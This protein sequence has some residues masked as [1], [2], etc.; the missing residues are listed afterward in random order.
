MTPRRCWIPACSR[1]SGPASSG[2]ASPQAPDR[3]EAG[4]GPV[5]VGDV[6]DY[7][8]HRH[9]HR[10]GRTSRICSAAHRHAQRTRVSPRLQA[11]RPLRSTSDPRPTRSLRACET[12]A[13]LVNASGHRPDAEAVSLCRSGTRRLN[14]NFGGTRN[15][16]LPQD[17]R[18][19]HRTMRTSVGDEGSLD[20]IGIACPRIAS[21]TGRPTHSCRANGRR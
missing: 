1:R 9:R 14:G 8:V 4:A 11:H 13:A 20:P 12:A 3:H 18:S 10:P 19:G 7:R 5:S 2:A 6:A 15:T 16:D 21:C 17:H